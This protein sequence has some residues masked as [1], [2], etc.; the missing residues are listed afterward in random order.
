MESTT[1]S[2]SKPSGV[3]R[4]KIISK[5]QK[6]MSLSKGTS[7]TAE[8]ELAAEM[9]SRMMEEHNIAAADLITAEIEDKGGGLVEATMGSKGY[10]KGVPTWMG[11]SAVA[12][13]QLFDCEVRSESEFTK[14][15]DGQIVRINVV[16]IYGYRVDVEVAQ[17]VYAYDVAELHRRCAEYLMSD[18]GLEQWALKRGTKG[19]K[20]AQMSISKSFLSGGSTGI[21]QKV[22]DL[23]RLRDTARQTN[24]T[25]TALVVCKKG[26][27][28]RKFG[29]FHYSSARSDGKYSHA[30]GQGVEA[31][32]RVDLNKRVIGGKGMGGGQQRIGG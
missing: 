2:N 13:A 4:A 1:D 16:R 23:I 27:L 3:D 30:H 7:Y 26:A 21:S 18:T 19:Q 28:V 15:K 6:M 12:I 14:D 32:R 22:R 5:V 29:Q 25:S 31:G 17:W 20:N 24:Q 11:V 9:A 10:E 8:A